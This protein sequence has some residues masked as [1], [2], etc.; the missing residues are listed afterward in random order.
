MRLLEAARR[1]FER[2]KKSLVS[3]AAKLE[4]WLRLDAYD[5]EQ[6]PEPQARKKNG[7][8]A[9]SSIGVCPLAGLTLQHEANDF[10]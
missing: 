3:T 7:A 10:C 9:M 1:G 5:H 2:A 6:Q 8:T 4:G